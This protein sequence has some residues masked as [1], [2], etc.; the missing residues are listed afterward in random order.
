VA[1]LA[2]G[3]LWLRRSRRPAPAGRFSL[4]GLGLL[5]LSI[6]LRFA[7]ALWYVET[8]EAW[9]ILFW[10]AGVCW[11]LGGFALLRWA[12]PAIGFLAFMIP[13]PFRAESLLSLPLQS[14]A[15]S[16]SC[17]LLQCLGEPAIAEGNVVL[18][19][20]SRLLVAEACSG[21][22]IFVSILAVAYVYC[23][24]L[25]KPWWTKLGVLLSV[26]PVAVITN[27]LRIVATGLAHEH[28]SGEWR[29]ALVHDLAGWLMAPLAA[30]FMYGVVW[31]LGKVVVQVE[32]VSTRELLRPTAASCAA[33]RK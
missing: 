25:E 29:N 26:P 5:A 31:H 16:L 15:T 30:L 28:V 23:V 9:S 22:R 18:I 33:P 6:V 7:G 17:W 8:L 21:L 1:P 3:F 10:L 24:L 14:L 4:G 19:N 12:L 20:D 11:L 27:S 13:L 2:L 32:T